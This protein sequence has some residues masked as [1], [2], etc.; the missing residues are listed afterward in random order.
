M[1]YIEFE[2][3]V[4]GSMYETLYNDTEGRDIL[5]VRMLDLFAMVNE[6][7]KQLKEKNK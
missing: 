6:V 5:V 2:K 4:L 3:L 7:E 1:N